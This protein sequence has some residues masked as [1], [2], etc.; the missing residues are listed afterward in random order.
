MATLQRTPLHGRHIELGGQMVNFG[1]WEMPVQYTAGILQEHLATR[2]RAGLFDVSHMGR[3]IVGGRDALPFLQYVLTNN[4]AALEVGR[5]QYTMIPAED[6]GA[7]DD[8]YLYRFFEDSYLLVVNA[9]NRQQDWEHLNEARGAFQGVT[10]SDRTG[11]NGHAEPSRPPLQG[12]ARR[13][14]RPRHP[15]R[16]AA[17]RLEHG[18]LRWR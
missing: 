17:Q 9:A 14:D 12:D 3:F 2:R 1:G 4:A 8:A 11:A 10:L 7:L 15:A 16:A 13:S 18:A 6:G 5:G